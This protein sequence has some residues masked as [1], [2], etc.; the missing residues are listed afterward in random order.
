MFELPELFGS[1]Y[2]LP[3]LI[4]V[5]VL[6]LVL[7][8][9]RLRAV[10]RRDKGT[11]SGATKTVANEARSG[12]PA[13]AA[14]ATTGRASVGAALPLSGDPIVGAIGG[15]LQGWGDL[16]PED[17]N[18]LRIYKP[19]KVAAAIKATELPKDL[20]NSDHAVARLNQL[21]HY[22]SSIHSGLSA[23]HEAKVDAVGDTQVTLPHTPADIDA[24]T[25]DAL[26]TDAGAP[27]ES[28]ATAEQLLSDAE[29]FGVSSSLAHLGSESAV[30]AEDAAPHES[31][32]ETTPPTPHTVADSDLDDTAET[33]QTPE[34]LWGSSSVTASESA[35]LEVGLSP[36]DSALDHDLTGAE[37]R[38]DEGSLETVVSFDDQL[39]V[40]E[41]TAAEE[42]AL[43]LD[44][45][46]LTDNETTESADAS[47]EAVEADEPE[48]AAD[49]DFF[50]GLGA[51]VTTAEDLM[52]LPMDEQA[53]MLAFL[54]AAELR[55]V[56]GQTTDRDLKRSIIDTLGDIG[57]TDSLEVLKECLDDPDPEIQVHALNAADRL[58]GV[59]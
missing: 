38:V 8:L 35:A 11:S 1:P 47:H 51:T 45:L 28:P 48:E 43:I 56:F 33:P 19:E 36:E 32:A 27:A 55:K 26:S 44:E 57:N 16:T 24:E 15:I 20:R 30:F 18:R 6:L 52:A 2:V 49:D 40:V 7:L 25:A 13:R 59:E 3:A 12:R 50:A 58:L 37:T 10:R 42:D 14:S 22:A 5:V 4:A 46:V 23:N 9:L 17:T 34:S 21:R 29:E 41:D 39:E 54:R 31:T 53:G